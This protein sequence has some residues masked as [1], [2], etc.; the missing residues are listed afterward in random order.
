ML[1]LKYVVVAAINC[2]DRVEFLKRMQELGEATQGVLMRTAKEVGEDAADEEEKTEGVE[3]GNV[4]D[5][6]EEKDARGFDEGF[7]SEERLGKVIADNTRLAHEKRDLEREIDE[8]HTRFRKL[9]ER[10]DKAQDELKEANDRLTA[11]LAGKNE[12]GTSRTG[13]AKHETV[14]A[15]L[16]AR[17][18]GLE[19]DNDELRRGNEVLKIKADKAQK[20]QDDYDEIKVDRDKL[21]RRANAAEKY[22]QKLEAGQEVE[23]ENS[24]LKQKVEELQ[25]LIKQGDSARV[26]KAEMQ[27]EIEEY[28]R[29]LPSIEQER[30]E[31]GE[32]KK[33]LEFEYHGLE[34]RYVDLQ[35]E[36][37]R[38]E[39]RVEEL[40]SR[41]RDDEDGA[42][43]SQIGRN[44][45]VHDLGLLEIDFSEEEA[46]LAEVL[47]KDQDGEEGEAN[48]ISEEEL[49]A[50]MSAMRAQA[51]AGS[52]LEKEN[53]L[54]AQKKLFDVV[55]RATRRNQQLK[56]QIKQ[57]NDT[58]SN[59]QKEGDT[60][61]ELKA[62][63]APKPSSPVPVEKEIELRTHPQV[64]DERLHEVMLLNENL[65]RELNLMTSAWY[66]QNQR[67]ANGGGV[68]RTRG[69]DRDERSSFLGK[70]RK[71]VDRLVMG[72]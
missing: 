39:K 7:A 10:H 58:I 12:G 59:L 52:A 67:L 24:G 35:E 48:G 54:R 53:N 33:T 17:L 66:E 2:A 61:S 20:L 14:I 37:G 63:N 62:A 19:S 46:R 28:R 29:L 1:L 60:H 22:K 23:K 43:S 4:E 44:S 50:I 25:I 27:R 45:D 26:E 32:M 38:K 72:E 36:F 5:E 68:V 31:L 65:R 34:A 15:T 41:L 40:E 56:E 51:Q 55:E 69:I 13:D 49:R 8:A 71:V 18:Q 21:S 47:I 11:V 16:E 3:H 57:H 70:Q 42:T 30:H 64:S 6:S 9:Q